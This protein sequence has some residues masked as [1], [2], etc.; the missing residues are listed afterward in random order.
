MIRIISGGKPS[1]HWLKE[2]IFDYQKRLKKPFDLEWQFISEDKLISKLINWQP[3]SHHDYLII[4][5]ET[6][7]IHSS[8]QMANLFQ[9]V[10]NT[11]K[12]ITIIIGGAYGLPT[13]II[14]KADFVWSFSKL[15]FP[16]QLI[17]LM[18]TEQIYRIQQIL[19][20]SKYHHQ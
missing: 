15:V 6:G 8:P 5:D 12:S 14:N 10:F 7:T 17:R 3:D 13:E 16:H 20:N 4:L 11:G 2:A 18:L 19:S 9:E 1:T